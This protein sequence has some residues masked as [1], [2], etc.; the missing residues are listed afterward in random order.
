MNSHLPCSTCPSYEQLQIEIAELR[1]KLAH[2]EQHE[3]AHKRPFSD[4][5]AQRV[6]ADQVETIDHLTKELLDLKAGTPDAVGKERQ[7]C[8]DEC[9]ADE[10]AAGRRIADCIRGS[11]AAPGETA[12]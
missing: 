2:Y 1:A 8:I 7:R 12:T 9:L 5:F 6:I 3:K 11:A 10:S 4:R